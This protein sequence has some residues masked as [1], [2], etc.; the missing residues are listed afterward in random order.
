MLPRPELEGE[1]DQGDAKGECV[2]SDPP[3]EHNSSD[4]RNDNKERAKPKGQQSG[5]NQLTSA[6]A[7]VQPEARSRHH[8]TCDNR[9]C[10]T[11][12]H[13]SNK[14]NARPENSENAYGDIDDA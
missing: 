4:Q 1:Y 2:R 8:R 9:P 12:Q 10:T 3:G 14:G 6:M 13:E 7:H 11:Q 5:Q